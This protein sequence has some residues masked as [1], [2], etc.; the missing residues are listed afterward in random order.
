MTLVVAHVRRVVAGLLPLAVVAGCAS[1]DLESAAKA[2][3]ERAQTAYRQ[4]QAD[5]SVQAYAQLRLS[6]AQK[7]VQAAEQAKDPGEMQ[8]LGYV[9]E[10]KAQIAS[11]AG[12]IRKTEQDTQQLSKETSDILLQKREAE[13]KAA[14]ADAEAKGREAEQARMAAEARARDAEAKA[15][16]AEQAR[17]QAEQ[18]RT[19][20][21]QAR[22]Q[23]EAEANAR[24]AEQA[25]TAVL[26]KELSDLKA[27]QTDRGIVLTVGDVLFA[28]GKAEVAPG[29][30]RSIDKLAEFLRKNPK[31]NVLIEGHTDNTGTVD[32]NLN[33]SQQ[34]ADAVRGLLVARGIAPERITAKGYGPKYPLV[35]ND[36]PSG[37]Q[38]NRRVE[39]V[40]LNEGVSAES[41][42]R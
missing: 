27:Q 26:T 20:T 14:R 40:V 12:A 29:G 34:R 24:A 15:R 3:L 35:V 31:R 11:T 28:T 1:T 19:Q 38:Q 36:T 21:E 13:V 4:A 37:R 10:K 9:A 18:A 23:A 5:P 22:A 32:F 33:L 6:D 41:A 7:A 39:V 16:E 2:Q 30:Q 17:A 25:K 42:T 8:H